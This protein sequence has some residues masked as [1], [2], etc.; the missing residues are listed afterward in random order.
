MYGQTIAS[1]HNYELL[2]RYKA[3]K[4][5][6]KLTAKLLISSETAFFK[7]LE[8]LGYYIGSD[9]PE[10]KP[11]IQYDNGAVQMDMS[12]F[13]EIR[14]RI[15]AYTK[16]TLDSF[17]LRLNEDDIRRQRLEK[18][19]VIKQ[20]QGSQ[21]EKDWNRAHLEPVAAHERTD[22]EVTDEMRKH[23]DDLM[24]NDDLWDK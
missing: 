5:K 20:L 10:H 22:I 4:K 19:K 18:E 15:D 3:L 21:F 13:N 12:E 14:T 23:D 1:F 16:A 7:Y 11:F 17:I 24:D 2:A 6:H 9:D 8:S